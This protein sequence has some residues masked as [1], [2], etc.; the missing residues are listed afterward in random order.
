MTTLQVRI[1]EDFKMTAQNLS[2]TFGVSLSDLVRMAMKDFV[3]KGGAQTRVGNADKVE[4]LKRLSKGNEDKNFHRLSN[5]SM[6][7][8]I[9][10]FS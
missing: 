1:S 2:K 10:S 3:D 7:N 9:S 6:D 4:L 8:L 5:R